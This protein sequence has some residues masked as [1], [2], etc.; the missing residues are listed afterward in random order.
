MVLLPAAIAYVVSSQLLPAAIAYIVS[1]QLLPAAIAYVVS[2]QL[3]H[4]TRGK[5]M[6]L[7]V[8]VILFR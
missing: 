2:S 8:C 1:S 4:K 6:K 5:M 3:H 7:Y